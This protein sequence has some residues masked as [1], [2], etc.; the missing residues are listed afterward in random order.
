M[1]IGL[2]DP[3]VKRA[4]PGLRP[5][6]RRAGGRLEEPAEG[7]LEAIRKGCQSP[8]ERL[9]AGSP[10]SEDARLQDEEDEGAGDP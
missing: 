3:S 9:A 10:P 4:R 7:I 1:I 6:E 2:D 5:P 8:L